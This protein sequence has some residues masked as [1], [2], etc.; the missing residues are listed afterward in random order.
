MNRFRE[1]VGMDELYDLE[2]D[3][4][5]LQNLMGAPRGQALRTELVRE[6]YLLRGR[7]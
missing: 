2:Q 5:E 4:Y 7:P 3:P 6:L 1:L